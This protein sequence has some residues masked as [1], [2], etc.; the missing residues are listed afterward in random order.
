MAELKVTIR[1]QYIGGG[2]NQAGKEILD[3]KKKTEDAKKPVE[4]LSDKLERVGG[5]ART[6][7]DGL[8]IA[9]GSFRGLP[10][11]LREA[12][13]KTD[14]LNSSLAK[15]GLIA[16]SFAGGFKLMSAAADAFIESMSA[17]NE[18]ALA[19]DTERI[20]QAVARVNALVSANN[21]LSAAS[22]RS[23]EETEANIA[24]IGRLAE[25]Q[26][27]Y[28]EAVAKLRGT[29]AAGRTAAAQASAKTGAESTVAGIQGAREQ[30]AI[31]SAAKER[32]IQTQIEAESKKIAELL[33]QRR[34]AE[35]ELTKA[36][37]LEAEARQRLSE[38]PND[39]ARI[40]AVIT[41]RDAAAKASAEPAKQVAAANA[42][43]ESGDARIA[44]LNIELQNAKA[45]AANK[46][47]EL[48]RQ[49]IAAMGEL[50]KA[51]EDARAAQAAAAQAR[52]GLQVNGSAADFSEA[53]NAEQSA[54]AEV[55]RLQKTILDFSGT[56]AGGMQSM[57]SR[58]TD[59]SAAVKA[60]DVKATKAL[61]Q[62]QNATR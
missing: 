11:L 51:L 42:G 36:K 54:A 26:N 50:T 6:A 52:A 4:D 17:A 22:K 56:I 34:I 39:P 55:Q 15:A 8:E 14:V 13:D 3:L 18:A 25:A 60:A 29:E 9:N 48:Q 40:K 5:A 53:Y 12:S 20:E 30:L 49:S 33:E 58:L 43:I 37:Q 38:D 59:I 31:E 32:S 35:E 21:E 45:E 46:N 44:A 41:A 47:A 27:N 61:Q 57:A 28:V 10:G 19:F 62:I 2:V 16:G 23:R 7:K 24:S 1:T